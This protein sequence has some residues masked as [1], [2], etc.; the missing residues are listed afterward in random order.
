MTEDPRPRRRL[1]ASVSSAVR[2]CIGF[3]WVALASLAT[4]AVALPLLPWRQARIR[5]CNLYGKIVGYSIVRLAG[6]TPIVRSFDRLDAA[7]PAIYVANHT[8]TLDAFLCIWMCPFGG[9]GV[10]K[11]Q[12]YRIP[13]FGQLYMLSGHLALDRDD[14]EKAIEGLAGLAELVRRHGLSVW[15]M[16]EGTRSRDGRLQ[17][18]KLGFVHLA[19]ATGLPI[20]PVVI[21]GAHRTWVKGSQ[22]VEPTTIEIDVLEPVPTEHWRVETARQHAEEIHRLFAL[23]L[24]PEQQ[25]R[26]SAA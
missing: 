14:R 4:I 1:R 11:K 2:F 18:F 15:I 22:Y 13:F 26:A 24:G 19:L 20:V 21:R 17:P 9:S 5:L 3:A 6:V 12:V 10:M 25:P 23:R 7:H 16:P 8:S